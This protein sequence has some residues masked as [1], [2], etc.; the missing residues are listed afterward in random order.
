M[1][2]FSVDHLLLDLGP[3]LK[4]SCVNNATPLEKTYFF[5]SASGY[6]WSIVSG[7][8]IRACVPF[9]PQHWDPI[10]CSPVQTTLVSAIPSDSYVFPP[11]SLLQD[12]LSLGGGGGGE[13]FDRIRPF[14]DCVFSA[15]YLVTKNNIS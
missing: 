13:G 8:G 7:L 5:L 15:S 1:P 12:S 3:V 9:P 4:G 10:W 11:L 14:L 2:F 6:Q